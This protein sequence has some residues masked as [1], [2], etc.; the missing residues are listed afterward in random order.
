MPLPK[1]KRFYQLMRE[2]NA[3]LFDAFYPIH[4]LY[5]QDRKAHAAEFHRVGLPVVDAIRDWERRLCA[6]M[7]RGMNGQ[8]S[9]KVA[10]KFWQEAKSE[11]SHIELVGVHSSFE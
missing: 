9:N 6:G 10:E 2:Q 7:E 3:A 5:V 4:E 11:F 1:Y 8:Y